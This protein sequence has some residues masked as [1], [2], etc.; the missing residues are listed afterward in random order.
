MTQSN[1]RPPLA[2]L[3]VPVYFAINGAVLA[4]TRSGTSYDGAEQLLYTQYWD[5]GYGRSQPP[6]YTWIL[7][8]LHG[9]LACPSRPRTS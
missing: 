4:L 2:I 7:Q 8:G 6:L 3:L 1:R 9:V 5:W